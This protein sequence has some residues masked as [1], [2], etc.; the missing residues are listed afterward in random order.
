MRGFNLLNFYENRI[1]FLHICSNISKSGE[2]KKQHNNKRVVHHKLRFL[3]FN[4]HVKSSN[5]IPEVNV[6]RLCTKHFP[7]NNVN[8]QCYSRTLVYY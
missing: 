7:S 5:K 8:D 6:L 3:L 4:S 2:G 1:I